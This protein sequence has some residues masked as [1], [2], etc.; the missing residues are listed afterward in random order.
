MAVGMG[1][2]IGS[3]FV[4]PAALYFLVRDGFQDMVRMQAL[5]CIIATGLIHGVYFRLV[6]AG[7][8]KGEISLVYPIARGS[9]IA[10][11]AILAGFL[12]E[13]RFT[14]M[15]SV[16]IGL[17]SLGILSLSISAQKKADDVKA[18]ILALC[19]GATIVSYSLVDK[20]GVSYTNPVVYLWCMFLIAAVALTP[21][22]IRR[23]PDT[24]MHAA[25][26]QLGT[27]S[28]IG[29]GSTV[30]YLMILYAFTMGPVGYIVAVREFSVVL[31]ALAGMAF[32]KERFTVMKL[33]AICA[34]VAGII[35]IKL[36]SS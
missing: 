8:E 21:S 10:V 1:L 3:A 23:Y 36:G 28:I 14:W 33:V 7:Y 27:A 25:R 19:I 5:A 9:G 20:V 32:L 34:I 2:W 35:S 29:I 12:L 22:L 24:I 13:E 15:G 18:I 26:K 31:G 11:T 30:T 6:S 16:G 4:F 17:I